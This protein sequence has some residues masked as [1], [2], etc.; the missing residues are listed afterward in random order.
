[1]SGGVVCDGGALGMPD[2]VVSDDD[3]LGMSEGVVS[4]GDEL[5]VSEGCSV[6]VGIGDGG[7]LGSEEATDE[8][9]KLGNESLGSAGSEEV[10]LLGL[11]DGCR[12][13]GTLGI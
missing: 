2:G 4:D 7:E 10:S 13:G 3:A 12:E 1:M 5:C 9:E 8:G 6:E 11:P